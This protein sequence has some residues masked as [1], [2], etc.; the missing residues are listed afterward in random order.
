MVDFN[1]VS[2]KNKAIYLRALKIDGGIKM[3]GAILE[4]GEDYYTYLYKVFSGINMVQ[5]NYNWLIT[6]IVSYPKI[7]EYEDLFSK[8]YCWISGE[9]LTKILEKEDFQWIWGVLS[10]FDKNIDIKEVLNYSLP[11]ADGYE[12]FWKNPLSL[13]HPLASLEIVAWDSSST[14][15]IEEIA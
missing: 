10:G 8:E 6:D 15:I 7:K 3:Y 13:Q 5:K 11:Y 9:Q 1:R 14:L 4:K 2:I 12:G